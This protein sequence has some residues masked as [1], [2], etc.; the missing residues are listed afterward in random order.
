MH[1]F[2]LCLCQISLK[3]S[4][5]RLHCPELLRISISHS[6]HLLLLEK[7]WVL[8][9]AMAHQLNSQTD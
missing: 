7:K 9:L 4:L 8:Y 6:E 5:V 2:G 1:W 3:R